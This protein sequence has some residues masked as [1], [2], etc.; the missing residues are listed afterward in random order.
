MYLNREQFFAL[1]DKAMPAKRVQG[2]KSHPQIIAAGA[3]HANS[4]QLREKRNSSEALIFIGSLPV[5]II[6]LTIALALMLRPVA[7]MAQQADID[8]A[9]AAKAADG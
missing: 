4:Q 7:S 5:Q 2:T 6:A 3:C 9:A 1:R 8:A